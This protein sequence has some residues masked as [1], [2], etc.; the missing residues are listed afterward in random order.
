M[1]PHTPAWKWILGLLVMLIGLAISVPLARYAEQDDAPGGVMIALLIFIG[2]V[3]L[4]VRIVNQRAVHVPE[5][6][7]RS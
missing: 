6:S 2:A 4:A 1:V 3:I 7:K 5:D